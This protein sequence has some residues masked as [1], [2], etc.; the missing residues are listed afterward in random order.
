MLHL[1]FV[2]VFLL[3]S[4]SHDP[5]ILVYYL[6][7]TMTVYCCYFLIE[8]NYTSPIVYSSNVL[9]IFIPITLFSD[10]KKHPHVLALNNYFYNLL[11]YNY[12]ERSY[13]IKLLLLFLLLLFCCPPDCG[14]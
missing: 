8:C 12:F 11:S 2:L 13:L 6:L 3:K 14:V 7:E 5:H 4:L 10:A 1:L 9:A